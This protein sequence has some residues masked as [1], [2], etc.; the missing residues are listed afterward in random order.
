MS[1]KKYIKEY[2]ELEIETQENDKLNKIAE[3]IR[4]VEDLNNDKFRSFAIDELGMDDTE[5]DTVIYKM[6]RDF[7]LSSTDDISDD[8]EAEISDSD[9]EEFGSNIDIDSIDDEEVEDDI[10][11]DVEL[12]D[13]EL[14][15][16][17]EDEEEL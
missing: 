14:D 3:F 9:E 12:D 10:D 16:D 1:F 17:I 6:L 7:V 13:D 5:A 15:V 11:V 4:S 8:V 2:E